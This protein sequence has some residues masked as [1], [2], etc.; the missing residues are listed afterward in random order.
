MTR[1]ELDDLKVWLPWRD[2]LLFYAQHFAACYRYQD[3]F[4]RTVPYNG[5]HA[6]GRWRDQATARN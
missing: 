5:L 3:G 2:H 4:E 6:W 1:E